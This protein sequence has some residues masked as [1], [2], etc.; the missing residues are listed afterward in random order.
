VDALRPD[1]MGVYGYPKSTTP[2]IDKWAKTAAVFTNMHTVIPA[3]FPSF[4]IFMTG[5]NPFESKIYNNFGVVVNGDIFAGGHPISK[6]TK[7]LAELLKANGYATSA[8]V[9]N[10]ALSPDLTNL[11]KGFD[12][13]QFFAKDPYADTDKTGYSNFIESSLD[14]IDKN[15]NKSFFVWVHL[16]SPHAPYDPPKDLRCK[17]DK[18]YC[19]EI[20]SDGI[21]NWEKKRA[22]LQGCRQ[23]TLDNHRIGLF[24][25]LY[26]GE[27]AFDDSIIGKILDGIANRQ[28][29]KNTIVVF[30]GDHGEGFDHNY[31][32]THTN[33][34]YESA[35]KIPFLIKYPEVSPKKIGNLLDN[36]SI[37]PS[38]LDLLG[39]NYK[40]TEISGESF[41]KALSGTKISNSKYIYSSNSNVSK[42]AISD[43]HFKYIYSFP[44]DS[45][46]INGTSEELF[47][48]STDPNEL[49]NIIDREPKITS[50]LKNALFKY[51]ARYNLPQPLKNDVITNV[52][53]DASQEKI[54]TVI[55]Q[56]KS[57]GY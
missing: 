5:K 36:V 15:K 46:T 44:V 22:G 29:D 24:E 4:S 51:F 39:I 42:Y 30:Y 25:T 35:T 57:L 41:A 56:L 49:V 10:V 53:K 38:L 34:L 12:T 3:T 23:E 26:D 32:F 37:L 54:K 9:T 13:Y 33:V 2:N 11:N 18:N 47:N 48:L 27:I 20:Q 19:N 1:H 7:T 8:F 52:G 6:N 31:Y 43:G 28:L 40:K 21:W 17:F 55:D 14:W 45:C 16:I 50:E